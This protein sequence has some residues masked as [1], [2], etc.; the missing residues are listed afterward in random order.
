MGYD[1]SYTL[2]IT[3]ANPEV[4]YVRA[5]RSVNEDAEYCLDDRG[6]PADSGSWYKHEKDL[7]DFSK[8][9]PEVL[10]TLSGEG[11]EAGDIWKKYFRNGKCQVAKAKIIIDEFDPEKLI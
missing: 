4:D 5:L 10:F 7:R 6:D 3:P 8:N 2:E 11:S 1:T 9:Y